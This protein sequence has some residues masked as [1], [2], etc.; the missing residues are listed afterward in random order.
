[1]KAYPKGAPDKARLPKSPLPT[2]AEWLI[3]LTVAATRVGGVNTG[4]DTVNAIES[5]GR[6]YNETLWPNV[7]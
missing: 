3:A 6:T 7:V 4:S 5:V 1:M 2:W